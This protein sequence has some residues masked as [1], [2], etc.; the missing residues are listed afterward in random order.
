MHRS[1]K[2]GL[3]GLVIAG[4][5]G[6]TA[7][8]A[9][10]DQSKTVQLKVDGQT[11]Q[12]HTKA[13]DVAGALH[14]ANVSIGEHDLV[15]PDP[16]SKI[17]NGELVVVRRG[18]L[19]HL[20]VDGRNR[21]VW[22]NADS[23]DEALSQL[24]FD[25]KSLI[26]VSRSKRLDSGPT[27]MSITSP[28][29]VTFRVDGRSVSVVSPGPTV[30]AAIRDAGITLGGADKLTPSGPTL[31]RDN[32]VVRVQRVKFGTAIE[33]HDVDF[34]TTTQQD[35]TKYTDQKSVVSAGKP[36]VDQVT[37]L[38][39]YVDG[40]LTAKIAKATSHLLAPVNEVLKVG[41][42]PR[43]VVPTPAPSG[44]APADT[45]GRNW[46]AVAACESGGNWAINT[47]NGFYGGLQFDY[48][49]WLSNGGGAYAPTAN[50]ASRAQQ[51]AIANKVADARGSSPWPV[52]GAYL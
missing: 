38:L 44:A 6:G 40:K 34:G 14:S 22:V 11:Q 25:A 52:C 20:A 21:D 33:K 30:A 51:I 42:K 47:G 26:S 19:L 41:T 23:V 43:P 17:A 46:D 8:W 10:A 3:Y 24:G 7:V 35:S 9:S 48:G 31:I 13:N 29:L 36:G 39:I 28:K 2:F 27:T 16:A 37:Y 18:H 15:A 1:I 4:V 12:I 49:T 50:L 5:V 45:S 32:L